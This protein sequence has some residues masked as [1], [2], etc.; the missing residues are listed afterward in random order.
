MPNPDAVEPGVVEE[1]VLEGGFPASRRRHVV[2]ERE[3]RITAIATDA[4]I[5]RVDGESRVFPVISEE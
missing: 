2:V 4:R 3:M 5:A 1:F